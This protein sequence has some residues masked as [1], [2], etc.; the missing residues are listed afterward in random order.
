[1]L[2]GLSR[3]QKI[4]AAVVAGVAIVGWA[5][6]IVFIVRSAGLGENL[7]TAEAELA[8]QAG[9]I[10]EIEDALVGER[11]AAGSLT[12][13]IKQIEGARK[14]LITVTSQLAAG[15]K[16]QVALAAQAQASEAELAKLTPR[17]AAA[18]EDLAVLTPQ[19]ADAKARLSQVRHEIAQQQ[20][21]RTGAR[22]A[23]PRTQSAKRETGTKPVAA[24]RPAKNKPV[25]AA[26]PA[27]KKT[28]ARPDARRRFE[29][30]DENGDGRIDRQE[31]NIKKVLFLDWVDAKKDGYLTMDET[32]MSEATFKQFDRDG[33][34][35]ISQFEFIDARM[36]EAVDKNRDG[37]VTYEEFERI[38]RTA[39]Q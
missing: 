36:F 24:A 21:A 39:G 4:A 25:A 14:E 26:R 30:V 35:K 13:I 3:I 10:S 8:A 20:I 5:T 18:R 22:P 38:L 32:V 16:E 37:F 28:P 12:A 34:G 29:F 33:D 1:M 23:P 17:V 11:A 27:K 7:A 15:R 9:K 6:A 31:F 2:A 19:L